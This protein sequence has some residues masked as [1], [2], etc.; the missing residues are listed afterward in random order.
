MECI[1]LPERVFSERL[2]FE[3]LRYEDA[4]E[5]FYAY[6][7]KEEATKYVS[8][9]T[10]TSIRDTNEYLKNAKNRWDSGL[11]YSYSIRLGKNSHLIGSY[12]IIN[13]NGRIQFGYIL[14]PTYWNQGIATEAC[15]AFTTLLCSLKNIYRI[16]TFVDCD[17]AASIR[18]LEKCGYDLEAKLSNW[19]RFPNQMNQVKDCYTFVLRQT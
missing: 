15:K 3:R 1:V 14:S 13:E 9:A 8:W 12:G 5:I 19:M 2:L 6:A 11:D 10:H 17:H 4:T 18:V 16:G 7:S